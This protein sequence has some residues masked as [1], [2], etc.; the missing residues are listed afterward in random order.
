MPILDHV[1]TTRIKAISVLVLKIWQS[2]EAPDL[3]DFDWFWKN[4]SKIVIGK[5]ADI[6]NTKAL[7]LLINFVFN[8]RVDPVLPLLFYFFLFG[9]NLEV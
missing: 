7:H 5:S 6:S 3:T 2:L 4:N 1:F 8:E 9:Q